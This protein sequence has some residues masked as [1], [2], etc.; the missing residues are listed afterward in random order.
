VSLESPFDLYAYIHAIVAASWP[1][2]IYIFGSRRHI[3]NTSYG[4]DIDLLL[5]PKGNVSTP[6]VRRLIEEP[7]IDAFLLDGEIAISVGNDTRISLRRG[8]IAGSL[9]AVQIWNRGA[10][11]TAGQDYRI[12]N[13]LP[14]KVP[15]QTVVT[16]GA[17]PVI[18]F[19]ALPTEFD[20]V[21]KRIPVGKP[22][23]HRNLPPHIVTHLTCNS[24]RKRLIVVVLTGVAS[25]NA[26]V[27]ATQILDYFDQPE[28]A[29]LVGITAG[30]K[31]RKTSLGDVLVPIATVDV[32]AGKVTPK[33]KEKAGLTIQMIPNLQRAIAAWTRTREWARK[34]K[35]QK[36]RSSTVPKVHTD[37]TLACTASV[38]AYDKFA[39][40]LR[41]WNRTVAG[42]EMEAVGIATAT[43]ERCPLLV[44]KSIADWADQRKSNRWHKYC[45]DLSADLVVSLLEEG[46]I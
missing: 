20:A 32:E 22:K 18:L 46:V 12:L 43:V 3:S 16:A 2:E 5:V 42:I 45:M 35:R 26:G 34:W 15:A 33:G 25:V 4:S 10:G 31:G 11:W 17:H 23:T 44:V 39:Q 30:L 29:I 19:C 36:G 14:H 8:D 1:E 13:I 37:C 27:A 28:L 40:K 24:G 9:G 21:V 41:N 38:I 6:E 7:Y